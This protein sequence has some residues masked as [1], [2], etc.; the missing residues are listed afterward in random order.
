MADSGSG[1]ATT[2]SRCYRLAGNVA[3]DPLQGI[4]GVKRQRAR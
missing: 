3:V 1:T 4:G 2:I